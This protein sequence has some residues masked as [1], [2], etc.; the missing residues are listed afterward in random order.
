MAR[1]KRLLAAFWVPVLLVIA[2]LGMSV[3]VIAHHSKALSPIDEWVYVDYLYK[4]PVEGMVHEGEAIGNAALN[5]MAC[6]GVRP[7]GPMGP[8]CGSSY[9]NLS[10][11]PF[12]GK[13]SADA[14][15]PVYFDTTWAVGEAIHAVT[16]TSELTSWRLTSA[17]WLAIASVLLYFLLRQWRI[18]KVV[19]FAL[20]VAM[21]ASPFAWWTYTY[22]STDAPSLPLGILLLIAAVK[23]ERGKWSGWWLVAISIIAVLFKVTNILAVC[24]AALFLLIT[25]LLELKRTRWSGWKSPRPNRVGRSSLALPLF[26]AS[27]VI[28]A[29]VAQVIWLAIRQA[30]AI[31]APANQGIAIPLTV[32]RLAEQTV[33]FLPGTIIANVNVAGS[34]NLAYTIPPFLIQPLSW[35]TVAGV[36]GAFWMLRRRS[37]T[38]AIV[39]AVVSAAVLFAPMLGLVV[40]LTTGSY[41]NLPPRYGAAILGGFLLLAGLTL[42]NR[43]AI[44]VVLV[45][46]LGLF[47]FVVATAPIYA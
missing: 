12:Q 33:N 38:T 16:G 24:L 45:Y 39:I 23:F 10:A 18:R 14:Y 6:D 29:A 20:G 40:Y 31:G 41:F 4:V 15:T 1:A 43:W 30:V 26:A 17:L 21:I 42:R 7:Y 46:A 34:P 47:A 25:W 3:T 37:S 9:R 35:I 22:V 32:R 8:P 2:S 19:I 13:T 5:I 36:I 27:S 11:F 44:G 28:S